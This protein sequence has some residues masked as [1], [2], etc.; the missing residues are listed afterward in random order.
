MAKKKVTRKEL[1]KGPDEFLT[2]SARAAI[3]LKA[4]S[5]QL[6]YAGIAVVVGI[7]VYMGVSAYLNRINTK[8]L[9]A[10]NVAYS[11]FLDNMDKKADQKS[12]EKT[13][14]L[15]EKVV[16]QYGRSKVSRLVAPQVA[17]IKYRE[18]KY[19]E[20]ITLQ[21]AVEILN[22]VVSD[23]D[24][25]FKEQAMLA[26]ARIYPLL[27]QKEKAVKVLKEFVSKYKASP[28]LPL[29]KAHLAEYGS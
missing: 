9:E 13:E 15:F 21:K 16:Q 19:D 3:F 24:G 25:F 23:E 12:L 26:L 7:L 17:Y 18:K 10:Y 4:H 29:A 2:F 6:S 11:A 28:F 22:I 20:A 5:T 27:N 14:K 8:G 1:L